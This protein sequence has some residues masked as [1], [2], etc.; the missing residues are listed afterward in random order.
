MFRLEFPRLEFIIEKK[1]ETFFLGRSF[2]FAEISEN[3]MR[4]LFSKHKVSAQLANFWKN[5]VK[6]TIWE[7]LKYVGQNNVFSASTH[8]SN[9]VMLAPKL[10]TRV[11]NTKG[12]PF[13]KIWQPEL[14][15]AGPSPLIFGT[16]LH[17][18]FVA[19][20]KNMKLVLFTQRTSYISRNN[21]SWNY[22][23]SANLFD[24]NDL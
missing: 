13:G 20:K 21:F 1:N 5:R 10:E 15:E 19:A 11:T 8:L 6:T 16:L 3:T 4:T 24:A 2:W 7:L 18:D 12:E 9:L 17:L 14:R 22:F 23:L